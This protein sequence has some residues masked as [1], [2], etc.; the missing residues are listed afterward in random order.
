M[1]D[2][3]IAKLEERVTNWMDTTTEYRKALC[4]KLDIIDKKLG[5]LP[6]STGHDKTVDKQL[7]GIWWLVSASL[8]GVVSMG[9]AWGSISKQVDINTERWNRYFQIH[10]DTK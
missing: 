6:C 5:G 4:A 8:I 9:I 1:D 10:Q 3:R 7:G 2:E